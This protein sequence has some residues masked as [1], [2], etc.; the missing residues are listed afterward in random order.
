ML[1]N[2]KKILYCIMPENKEVN[3]ES[4]RS[5][6]HF[7]HVIYQRRNIFSLHRL[8]RGIQRVPDETAPHHG[9][10]ATI[11]SSCSYVSLMTFKIIFH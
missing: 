5:Y 8:L 1:A 10:Q 9:K 11:A 7:Y 2:V 4:G 6:K 3:L